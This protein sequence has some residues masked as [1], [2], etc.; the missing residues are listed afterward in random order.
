MLS[1]E[2]SWHTRAQAD[3]TL[4]VAVQHAWSRL[5]LVG[6]TYHQLRAFL[7]FLR[8]AA[9]VG[10]SGHI[11]NCPAF[12]GWDAYPYGKHRTAQELFME[13][14]EKLRHYHDDV[15]S[16]EEGLQY[17]ALWNRTNSAP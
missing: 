10:W 12:L 16:V 2:Q 8:S 13:E 14:C 1:E 4:Q 7:T 17:I 11:V 6:S 3:H 15:A 9:R 5:L